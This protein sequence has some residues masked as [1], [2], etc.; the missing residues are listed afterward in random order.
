MHSL[1]IFVNTY[2]M[3]Q[4]KANLKYLL[5]RFTSY[6]LFNAAELLVA[7]GP[8]DLVNC[9]QFIELLLCFSS[10]ELN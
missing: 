8:S 9:K 5:V 10:T 7:N 3:E 1:F 6:Y 4:I 2:D